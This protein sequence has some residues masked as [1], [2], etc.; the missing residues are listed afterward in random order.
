MESQADKDTKSKQLSSSIIKSTFIPFPTTS[1]S[2]Q[3]L[4]Q[5]HYQPTNTNT[6]LL[7]PTPL[8]SSRGKGNLD[9][10]SN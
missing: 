2:P 8:L 1:S 10:S 3:T 6:H 9:P 4:S 7:L 5:V